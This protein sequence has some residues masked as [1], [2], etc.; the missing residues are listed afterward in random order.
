MHFENLDQALQ[1]LQVP[2]L[3]GEAGAAA[4]GLPRETPGFDP[5]E[6]HSVEDHLAGLAELE[7]QLVEEERW[8]EALEVVAEEYE[9]LRRERGDSDS[10]TLEALGTYAGVLWQL[11]RAEDARELLE[12]LVA[13]RS[14]VRTHHLPRIAAPCFGVQPK[15]W[16]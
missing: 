3:Q 12:E 9:L 14:E 7:D 13:K 10:R 16:A 8:E 1:D 4:S 15:A 11:G 2:A 6:D 5:G